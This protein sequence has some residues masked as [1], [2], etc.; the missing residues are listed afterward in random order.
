MLV[1]ILRGVSGAGKTTYADQ[2]RADVIVSADRWLYGPSG[3]YEWTI[4]RCREAHDATLREYAEL[5][6]KRTSGHIVVD[7]TGISNLEVAPYVALAQAHGYRVQTVALLCPP[8]TAARR[9]THGLTVSQIV[10]QDARIRAEL[11]TAP[12]YFNTIVEREEQ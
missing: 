2:L 4:S 5:V 6:T 12:P 8:L 7:N 11:A 9:T 3:H 1:T 10:D